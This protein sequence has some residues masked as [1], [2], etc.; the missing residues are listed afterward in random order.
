MA[1]QRTLLF[2]FA[3]SAFAIGCHK[4]R[5]GKPESSSSV[6]E[7]TSNDTSAQDRANS[8]A[9]A[10]AAA[11][12]AEVAPSGATGTTDTATPSSATDT[13][14]GADKHA[15]SDRNRATG[16]ASTGTMATSTNTSAGATG[17]ATG[18]SDTAAPDTAAPDTVTPS[19]EMAPANPNDQMTPEQRKTLRQSTGWHR[20]DR[21]DAPHN[22]PQQ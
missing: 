15:A 18:T 19:S 16:T 3:M 21:N 10:P 1:F 20:S 4:D 12:T 2:T 22:P 11:G 9:P 13:T 7:G 17:T 6:V 5:T 14:T 8:T